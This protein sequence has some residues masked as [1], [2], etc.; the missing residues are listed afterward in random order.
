MGDKWKHT[1]L[2]SYIPATKKD[3]IP[4]VAYTFF[5]FVVVYQFLVSEWHSPTQYNEGRLT[6]L[7]TSCAETAF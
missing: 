7:V 2:S 1:V 3:T 4:H 6:V 5:H